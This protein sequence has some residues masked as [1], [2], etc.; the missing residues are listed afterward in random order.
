MSEE[1]NRVTTKRCQIQVEF[2]CE[3]AFI[4]YR[5][6]MMQKDGRSGDCVMIG[7]PNLFVR[8]EMCAIHRSRACKC[9]HTCIKISQYGAAFRL[10]STSSIMRVV[11]G[12][13]KSKAME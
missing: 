2:L 13:A 10:N 9:H 6:E 1:I 8:N 3:D 4:D 5:K 11:D 7:D 12:K